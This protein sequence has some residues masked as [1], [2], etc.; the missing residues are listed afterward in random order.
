MHRRSASFHTL[1]S[2]LRELC[3]QQ[4]LFS[5]WAVGEAGG[6]LPCMGGALGSSQLQQDRSDGDSMD[7]G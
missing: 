1:P 7:E 4:R 5:P 6:G 2:G 3:S